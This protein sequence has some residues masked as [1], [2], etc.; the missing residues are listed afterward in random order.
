MGNTKPLRAA[1]YLRRSVASTDESVSLNFQEEEARAYAERR[2]WT[3]VEV[4]TDDGVSASEKKPEDRKGWR[5]L[6]ASDGW[7][8]VVAWKLD[9]VLRSMHDLWLVH[10]WLKEHGK[11]IATVEGDIDMTTSDGQ[12]MATIWAAQAQ[13]EAEKISERVSAARR[14][15]MAERR[16]PGGAVAYGWRNVDN[17]D[18]PGKV[19]RQDPNRIEWVKGMVER[20][21]RGDTLYSIKRWLD[22]AGAPLPTSGQRNRTGTGWRYITVE[23]LLRNP[24]LAG[25]VVYNPGNKTKERGKAL[26]LGE[27]GLPYINEAAA[28]MPLS[29]WRAMVEKLDSRDSPQ[30]RPRSAKT[31]TSGLLSGFMFCREHDELVKMTRGTSQGRPSYQCRQCFQT[32]SNFEAELVEHFL[33]MKGDWPRWSKVEERQE[34]GAADLADIEHRLGEL[35]ELIREAS[36]RHERQRLRDEQDNL[37]DLRDEKRQEPGRMV[38]VWNPSD[39]YFSELW[40]MAGDDVVEQRAILK[41]ALQH[42]LVSRP[43]SRGRRRPGDA[44]KRLECVWLRPDEVGPRPL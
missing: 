22:E 23:S 7:D 10:G 26:L 16:Q 4:F 42:V 37:F 6:M 25:A 34:N 27:N 35:D 21:Q 9:R 28:I 2:G 36:D 32:I 29:E 38:E 15:L 40:A 12:V 41:D 43:A 19:L 24:I 17:P 3:V 39:H 44:L 30:S 8:V 31:R 14:K 18:G 5:A 33:E 11:S 20:C 1:L 13:R